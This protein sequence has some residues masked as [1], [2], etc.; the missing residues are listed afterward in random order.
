MFTIAIAIF[1][2]NRANAIVNKHSDCY[3]PHMDIKAF[4]EP[5]S[6]D[7]KAAFAERAK[8][9]VAYLSQL[10]NG[11]RKAGL[12]TVHAIE[13]ASNGSVTGHDLRPDIFGPRQ[14][15]AA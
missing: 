9:S 1:S 15:T 6:A 10:A 14:E 7:E 13:Q 5:M 4:I 8:T 11:H 2:H 12:K 3:I